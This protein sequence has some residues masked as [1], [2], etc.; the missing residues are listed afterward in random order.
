MLEQHLSI[1]QRKIHIRSNSL[2][3]ILLS[4]M[5]YRLNQWQRRWVYHTHKHTNAHSHKH[6]RTL[7][8]ARTFTFTHSLTL[9]LSLSLSLTHTHTHTHTELTNEAL[10]RFVDFK[11]GHAIR[12]V[13]YAHDPVLQAKK[14]TE[15]QGVIDRLIETG[16]CYGMDMNV[17]ESTMMRTSR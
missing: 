13:K 9:S 14:E 4:H 7:T 1:T 8:R 16:G 2:F 17:E 6:T 10:K 15:L 3:T 11:T 5:L 12:T